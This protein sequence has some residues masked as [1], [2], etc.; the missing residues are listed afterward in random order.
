MNEEVFSKVKESL[1]RKQDALSK[2]ATRD[3]EAIRFKEMKEDYRPPYWHDIDRIIYNLSYARYSDKTQVFSFKDNDHVSKRMTHVQ[4]VSKVARTLGRMLNLNED[5]IEAAALGH[6]I[7]HTPLG[8]LGEKI[9]DEISQRELGEYFKHNVQGV[10]TYMYINKKGEGS[11]LTLQV[12]DAVLCH[13]GEI[14]S[15]EYHPVKKT[16][17]EFLEQYESAYTDPEI[18]RKLIPMTLEGCV[19]RISDIIAYIGRDIEDAIMLGALTRDQIPENIKRVLGDNNRDIIATINSDIINNSYGKPYIKMS[20]EVYQAIKDLKDFNYQYIYSKANTKE[21]EEYYRRGFNMLYN[22][23]L[24]DIEENNISSDI[25][26]KF[27]NW[28]N[29]IYRNNTSNKR[30]VIDFIAGMT[31]EYFMSKYQEIDIK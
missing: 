20:D 14:V 24:N 5:L 31:D 26:T 1:Q 10:R 21:E 18:S 12:L 13:N 29:D 25:Y 2:Y 4:L 6:D 9:L 22:K 17:E 23:Y 27:L 30:I 19:V 15:G 11:N 3:N 8:H 28:K 7:G 16:K